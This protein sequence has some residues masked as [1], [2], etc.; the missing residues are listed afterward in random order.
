[1]GRCSIL[2]PSPTAEQ[3]FRLPGAG[4]AE[5]DSVSPVLEKPY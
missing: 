4:R 5:I 2:V 1:M 3:Y